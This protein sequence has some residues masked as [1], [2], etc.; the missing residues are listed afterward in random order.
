VTVQLTRAATGGTSAVHAPLQAGV[1]RGTVVSV[2]ATGV[3]AR[4]RGAVYEFGL[5]PASRVYRNGRR[6]SSAALQP[7][8]TITVTTNGAGLV[9]LLRAAS[10][11]APASPAATTA[12]TETAGVIAV[13]AALL[14]LVLL[15]LPVL[16]GLLRR[17]RA[18]QTGVGDAGSD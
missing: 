2:A 15:L 9:T 11:A 10:S 13:V 1:W 8:D 6:S 3:A 4:V 16:V 17:H 18:R 14:V 12:S 7:G 5:A